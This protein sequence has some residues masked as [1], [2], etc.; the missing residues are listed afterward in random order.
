MSWV[1]PLEEPSSLPHKGRQTIALSVLDDKSKE[2]TTSELNKTL[3]ENS[4][5]GTS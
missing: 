2:P 1:L 3:G 4:N 5:I